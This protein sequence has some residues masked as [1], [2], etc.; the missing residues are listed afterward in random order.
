MKINSA[1]FLSSSP[2]LKHCPESDLPEIAFIG[3]SNVGKSS[4]INMLTGRKNLA[5]ISQTPGKTRLINHFRINDEWMLVDL[6]GYGYAKLSKTEKEKIDKMIRGYLAKRKSL[7]LTFQLI[8]ARHELLPIDRNFMEW[9]IHNR[10]PFAFLLTKTD[11]LSHNRLSA[12]VISLRTAFGKIDQGLIAI[13][14]SSA[15]NKGK[16]EILDHISEILNR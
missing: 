1:V 14:T 13:P 2:D 3:R 8:D 10:L 12:N 11:K 4:L 6:P 15:K 5:K 9:L 7:Q 16:E